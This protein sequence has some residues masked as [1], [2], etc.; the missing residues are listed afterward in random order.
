MVAFLQPT[1]RLPY[2]GDDVFNANIDGW[3]GYEH[4]S[5]GQALVRFLD[6]TNVHAGRFYPIWS[7]LTFGEFHFVHSVV[8]LKILVIA[9]ILA[10]AFTL[11]VFLRLVAPMLA[12]PALALL[13][14]TWQLRFFDDPI[15]QASLDMQLTLEFVLIAA[16]ALVLF[17]QNGRIAALALGVALYACA[18][19]TYEPAYALFPAFGM[20]AWSYSR[21]TR[22]SIMLA[23][24]YGLPAVALA[25]ITYWIH[26][27][28]PVPAHSQHDLNFVFGPFVRTLGVNALGAIPLS[29]YVF[30][31]QHFFDGPFVLWSR[32]FRSPAEWMVF[33]LAFLATF[34]AYR[35]MKSFAWPRPALVF[36][37][38]LWLLSGTLI[39]LSPLWQ[40]ELTPGQAYVTGYLADFGVAIILSALSLWCVAALPGSFGRL[41][42]AICVAIVTVATFDA[43]AVATARYAPWWNMTIPFGLES[44]LLA[45]A[46]SGATVYLDASYPTQTRFTNDTW[47][48]KYFLY[49]R[50][51]RVFFAKPLADLT[52]G[53]PEHAFVVRAKTEGFDRGV[54][55]AGSMTAVAPG[56]DG[57]PLALMDRATR[58]VRSPGASANLS[59]WSSS[60]GALPIDNIL[61]AVPSAT[62]LAYSNAFYEKESDG[63]ATWRW[64][65]RSSYFDVFNPTAKLRLVRL[66][67][68]VRPVSPAFIHIVAP[69]VRLARRAGADIPIAG[70]LLVPPHSRARI[71]VYSD[72]RPAAHPPDPR[73]VLYEVRNAHLIE[74]SCKH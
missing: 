67:F 62:I 9:S 61:E 33:S 49:R 17:L 54:A 35:R 30:N 31:P 70:N 26:A 36:A 12:I 64:A 38:G 42:L 28:H 37:L 18:C 24:A 52:L 5:L 65:S 63:T 74:P 73:S 53:S 8:A 11:Y 44:G 7:L 72:G 58:Y 1:L 23:I 69:F 60:C 16:I 43:N 22:S 46:K 45:A 27:T 29:Y 25:G 71:T 15:L 48:A 51:D 13:P 50:T 19:M 47:H 2:L 59:Q 10:N 21:A 56:P 55:V 32:F 39:S 14:A 4:L 40:R 41:S 68:S 34:L 20:L 57:T 66:T 6:F 3:I